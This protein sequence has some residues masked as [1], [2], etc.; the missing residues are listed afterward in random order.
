MLLQQRITALAYR[1]ATMFAELARKLEHPEDA[2]FFAAKAA[3]LR[4]ATTRYWEC[5]TT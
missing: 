2:H 3:K 4:A 5:S 1:A